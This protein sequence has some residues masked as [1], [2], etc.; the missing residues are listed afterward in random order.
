MMLYDSRLIW[1]QYYRRTVYRRCEWKTI[2]RAKQNT[3][4]CE[5]IYVCSCIYYWRWL[6][7]P[8]PFSL[9]LSLSTPNSAIAKIPSHRESK[10]IKI[11]IFSSIFRLDLPIFSFLANFKT[12]TEFTEHISTELVQIAIKRGNVK[13]VYP[14]C[15][16]LRSKWLKRKWRRRKSS[17]FNEYSWKPEDKNPGRVDRV[18]AE[19]VE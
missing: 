6:F 14:R 12:T 1:I 7:A 3:M 16:K 10:I 18:S 11:G 4:A 17:H 2:L 19:F 5:E 9:P 8:K 13:Q 15:Q